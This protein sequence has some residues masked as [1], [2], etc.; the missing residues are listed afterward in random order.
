MSSQNDKHKLNQKSNTSSKNKM[1][2]LNVKICA[3]ENRIEKL[4]EEIKQCGNKMHKLNKTTFLDLPPELIEKVFTY[5]P[6]TEIYHNVR[7]VCRR[8]CEIVD[9]FLQMGKH[10]KINI[11]LSSN[12]KT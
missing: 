6:I 8:L 3:L 7:N 2:H 4:E 12:L 5:L 10:A 1:A 11:S 9:G